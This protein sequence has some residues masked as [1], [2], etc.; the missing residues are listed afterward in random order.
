MYK[1]RYFT[2]AVAALS[3]IST[4]PLILFPHLQPRRAHLQRG[5]RHT[6]TKQRA[7]HGG[8][9][10]AQ[11]IIKF[12]TSENALYLFAKNV[13]IADE[14]NQMK[15]DED[16]IFSVRIFRRRETELSQKFVSTEEPLY[17]KKKKRKENNNSKSNSKDEQVTRG[18]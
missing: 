8:T 16:I 2:S 4:S 18:I 13:D 11:P 3:H 12:V 10:D 1:V 9:Q 7:E 15:Y 6:D 5:E 17:S 14:D